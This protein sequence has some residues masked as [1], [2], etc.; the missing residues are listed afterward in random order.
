[1]CND[2]HTH[3]K[4]L[5][6]LLSWRWHGD[7]WGWGISCTSGPRTL[8]L[9]QVSSTTPDSLLPLWCEQSHW[10]FPVEIQYLPMVPA[11]EWN[12]P[13]IPDVEL[14]GCHPVSQSP[15][16]S[17]PLDTMPVSCNPLHCFTTF[18]VRRA[19]SEGLPRVPV[20]ASLP[21]RMLMEA[22][23]NWFSDL[24]QKEEA[25]AARALSTILNWLPRM[26]WMLLI[27][28]LL[29]KPIKPVTLG[30]NRRCGIHAFVFVTANRNFLVAKYFDKS[31]AVSFMYSP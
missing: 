16:F 10:L 22:S 25:A 24:D 31:F 21:S 27:P 5:F 17:Y 28:R 20:T 14:S 8:R 13:A 2:L 29:C 9:C 18:P 6:Q 7:P 11:K 3:R 30:K 23:R 12:L 19:Q 4:A 26:F 1:M 15:G